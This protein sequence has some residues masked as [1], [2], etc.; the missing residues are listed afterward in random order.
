MS[1]RADVRATPRLDL[2]CQAS[3]K[4]FAQ[5][6]TD[7]GLPISILINNAG[8]FK[9][10]PVHVVRMCFRLLHALRFLQYPCTH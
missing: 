3:T 2:G 1:Y 8:A 4:Q 5:W 10:S 7:S 9:R 6:V